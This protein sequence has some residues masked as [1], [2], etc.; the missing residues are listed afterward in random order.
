MSDQPISG[1]PAAAS[2]ELTDEYAVNQSGTTKKVTGQ[3][4]S[5]MVSVDQVTLQEAYNGGAVVNF[6]PGKKIEFTSPNNSIATA[7]INAAGTGYTQFDILNIAGGTAVV[8]GTVRVET[9][10][11]SG[12]ITSIS[13]WNSGIYSVDPPLAANAVTGGAGAGAAIDLTIKNASNVDHDPENPGA[14]VIKGRHSFFGLPVGSSVERDSVITQLG[15]VHINALDENIYWKKTGGFAKVAQSF[16]NEIFETL[17]IDPLS[18]NISYIDSNGITIV[19]HATGTSSLI[20]DNSSISQFGNALTISAPDITLS[21]TAT[22]SINGT[23]INF[24]PSTAF[25]IGTS[26]SEYG[27]PINRT[28][29][30]D[31]CLLQYNSSSNEYEHKSLTAVS[32]DMD[33]NAITGT[34]N[35]S[36]GGTGIGAY[37]TG[38]I[39]FASGASTL[40]KLADI[41]TGNV[42]LS[43][44]V[45]T[46]PT[47]GKVG[48]GTHVSGTLGSI[49]GG[50]GQTTYTNGQLLIGNTTGNTL[51]KATLTA[52]SGI[53]ITNGSGTIT[54]AKTAKSYGAIH[55][56][57]LTNTTGMTINVP[58]KINATTTLKAGGVNFDQPGASVP[59]LRYT[60]A[61]TKLFDVKFMVTGEHSSTNNDILIL[62]YKNGA[63]VTGSQIQMEYVTGGDIHAASWST[64][65]T[66]AQNDYVEIWAQNIEGGGTFTV[67]SYGI[68][69][70]EIE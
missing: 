52:G 37:T 40:S 51:S 7:V 30:S 39:L 1:L 3:Q 54:I 33:I 27:L 58:I 49:N 61:T 21:A 68:F 64:F 20:I 2:A 17:I 47:Y 13:V 24:K 63:L 57:Q 67:R 62:L 28:G 50:T 34:L 43:G 48:L 69:A 26:G 59:R 60:G 66:L 9:V 35:A 15:Y 5:D 25:T 14:I 22:F 16:A 18:G 12:A 10:N 65:V 42:L 4:I 31:N 19:D 11:G 41:A 29:T 56:S 38:D 32:G 6:T 8:T 45:A 36:K 53:N 70:N 44:G 23:I 46:A 55:G